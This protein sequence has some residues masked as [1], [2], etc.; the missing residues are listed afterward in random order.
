MSTRIHA[1]HRIIPHIAIEI[2]IPAVKP[3]RI[4]A[5]PGAGARIV[6]ARSHVEQARGV[7][8]VPDFARETEQVEG[9]AG[10]RPFVAPSVIQVNIGDVVGD[11]TEIVGVAVENALWL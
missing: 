1:P 6:F 8:H 7:A 3:N 9:T 10:G 5:E 2:P 4:A 11:V